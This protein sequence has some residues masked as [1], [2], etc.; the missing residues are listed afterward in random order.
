MRNKWFEISPS[1]TSENSLTIKAS[2]RVDGGIKDHRHKK[3]ISWDFLDDPVHNASFSNA[4]G[5]DLISGWQALT[6][7]VAKKT[8]HKTEATNSIK[9]LKMVHIKK[10]NLKNFL[11]F[12]LE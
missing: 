5:V 1:G 6:C 4:G 9:A 7:L 8:K 11:I 2:H 10:K 3:R 12:T